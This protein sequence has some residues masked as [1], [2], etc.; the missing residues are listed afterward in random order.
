MVKANDALTEMD[1]VCLFTIFVILIKKKLKRRQR[2]TIQSVV[3]QK[4]NI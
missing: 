4:F 2:C 1:K 3:Y